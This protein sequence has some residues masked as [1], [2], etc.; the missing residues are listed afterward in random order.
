MF[1]FKNLPIEVKNA[2]HAFKENHPGY[3]AMISEARYINKP[4]VEIHRKCGP[5]FFSTVAR[6]V[7]NSND[8]IVQWINNYEPRPLI[9]NET[10]SEMTE[11][12][13]VKLLETYP[14]ITITAGETTFC[15]VCKTHDP[16]DQYI[17][18]GKD[19]WFEF[20]GEARPIKVYLRQLAKKLTG[21]QFVANESDDAI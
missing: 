18:S 1:E 12:E 5:C 21:V 19:A 10:F 11:D 2:I 8:D 6:H 15:P 17:H 7:V 4:A 13:I 3:Y 20:H 14:Y 16:D 9:I